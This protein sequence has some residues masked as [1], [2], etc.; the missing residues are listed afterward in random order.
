MSNLLEKLKPSRLKRE[1]LPFIIISVITISSL[2][3]FSYQD[4]TGSNMY[5]PE[6]PTI[7][8]EVSSEISNSSQQCFIKVSPVSY[9]FIK[10]TWANRFLAANIRKRDSDGGFSFELFQREDLFQIRD[11]D[12][13][14]LLPPGKN[15]DSLRTKMAFDVYN[16][17]KENDSNYMLP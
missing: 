14:L 5:S 6:V 11:D 15:L 10:S 12:D 13:W 4:S 1:L 9:E 16:M 17:L 8:I 3:Y 7:N 2:I